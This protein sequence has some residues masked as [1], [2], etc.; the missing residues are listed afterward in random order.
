MD[1]T[2]FSTERLDDSIESPEPQHGLSQVDPHTIGRY[3]VIGRLGSGAFGQ[4]YLAH[5]DDLDRRVAIKVPR[6]GRR[7]QREGVQQYLAEARAVA[8]LDHANI[9]PVY[10][11]G[12]SED[13]GCYVVS[14]FVEG[15]DLAVRLSE[16][17]FSHTEAVELV[18]TV[19][20]SLHHAHSRGLVHRDIKPANILID[21]SGRPS[22]ADFGLAL[23]DEDF[24]TGEA[25]AGT[26]AYMSPEQA[27]GEGHRVDGRSDVF[28]LGIIFYELLAGRRPFR[29]SSATE[30]LYQIINVDARPPRQC[31][32]SIPKEL[33][34]ICLKALS[35]R[36][37]ERYNTAKD[38]AEDLRAFL[39]S[40]EALKTAVT[41]EV[42]PPESQG[43]S[44]AGTA[45]PPATGRSG[46]EV[47]NLR[48][49]PKGL[50]SFDAH[51]ADFFLELVPGAKDRNG[52]PE[53]LRFWKNRI[54]AYHNHETFKVGLIYG[55]SGCGKSSL[56]K[57][58]LLP[59]LA[60]N[61]HIVYAEA[62]P[63]ETEARL[64][65]GLRT[66]LAALP[67][68]L[69][70]VESLATI[71]RGLVLGSG[72]K[73]LLILDQFEQWLFANRDASGTELVAALR[74][75]DGE[76][77]QA[78]V[79]VRDDFWMAATR[80]MR[81]LE[82]RLVEGD[83]AA[84]VD[85][86]DP[87]HARNVLTAFG[88]A[89]GALPERSKDF[90]AD[91]RSFLERA[92]IDLVQD[93]KVISVRL[94]L[95]AQM[96]KAKPWTPA[97]L[98]A[99]GGTQ[100]VGVAFLDETFS[101]S[102]A[103]AEHRHHQR[104]AQ[105][106]LTALLPGSGT[107]IKGQMR[108]EAELRKAAGYESRP[109]DFDDLIRIL[110]DQLRLITP[111][112]PLDPAEEAQAITPDAGPYYQFTHDYLVPSLRE[113][114]TRRQR[115]TRQGRAQLILAERAGLWSAKPED[116]FL[117]S[118]VEWGS[119]RLL[120]TPKDW[121]APQRNM[122]RRAE[123][124]HGLR[125]L[126]LVAGLMLMVL[127]GL[128]LRG[129][130]VEAN[131]RTVSLGMVQQLVKAET[132]EV[133]G[134]IRAFPAHRR[135]IDP[136]LRRT[137]QDSRKES[138][139][140]LHA[141]LAL[142]PVDSA[143]ANY[144]TDRLLTASTVELPV[145]WGL[146]RKHSQGVDARLWQVVEDPRGDINK[147]FRA[148]CALASTDS[149]RTEHRWTALAPFVTERFLDMVRRNPAEYSTLINT[150]RPIRGYLLAPLQSIFRDGSRSASDLNFVTSILSDYA[151]DRPETLAELLTEA[152]APAFATLY[153]IAER[154]ASEVVPLL[155][156]QIEK[157]IVPNWR[158][159]PLSPAWAPPDP[160]LVSRIEE[161]Q[162]ML[163]ERFGFCQ[164]MRLN[165]FLRDAERL[166]ESG[167]RP[168]R[169][170]PYADGD[171]VRVA[172]IW[173]RDGARWVLVAGVPAEQLRREDQKHRAEKLLPLDVAGYRTTDLDG[174]P[175][176][177]YA[178]LWT[179]NDGRDADAR[180]YVG[181]TGDRHEHAIE[182]NKAGGF[183]PRTLHHF[184]GCDGQTRYSGIW[185]ESQSG[186]N[187]DWGRPEAAMRREL[188]AQSESRLLDLSLSD[189]EPS[190][191]SK[192]RSE[193]R[194]RLAD[195]ALRANPEDIEARFARALSCFGM[196]ESQNTL[197]D[198]NV[199]IKKNPKF[200][201]AYRC[202]AVVHARL[203][204]RD[205][206]LG[207]LA[208]FQEGDSPA[209]AK[210]SLA[211]VVAAE[212]GTGEDQSFGAL[213]DALKLAPS[214]PEMLYHACCALAQASQA[215]ATRDPSRS[216]SYARRAA[217]LLE[218]A[219]GNGYPDHGRLLEAIE[220]DPIRE[221]PQ[222]VDLIKKRNL[223]RLYAAVWSFE[224]GRDSVR[225][226]ALDPRA[227]LR[228]SRDLESQGYRPVSSS[229]ARTGSNGLLTTAMVWQR[230][231]VE[232]EAQDLQAER[233][234]RAAIALV[235]MGLASEV[236]PLLRHNAE[237]RLR[238]FIVNWLNPLGADFKAVAGGLEEFDSQVPPPQRRETRRTGAFLLDPTTSLRRA[239][240]L[241]LGTYGREG[242]PDDQRSR[243]TAKLLDVYRNDPDAGIHGAAEWTL[244]QWSGQERQR[245]GQSEL[246][247]IK[248]R[249]DRRWFVN[250]EG[251]TF[252]VIE[253]PVDFHMGSPANESGRDRNEHDHEVTIPRR[254][255]IATKEVTT[256]QYRR[257]L[258]DH[259]QLGL[260]PNYVKRYSPDPDGPI[261]AVSWYDA[262]SYCNWLS[263]KEGLPK[264]DWA[265]L[266]TENGLYDEGMTIPADSLQRR[267]YRLPT[268]AEWEYACRSGT[269]TSCFYGSSI[270]LRRNY[271]R[272][273]VNSGD[274]AWSCG[275]LLP[276]DL[277]LFDTLG[278]VFEWC[279]ER[280]REYHESSSGMDATGAL[281]VVSR[282]HPRI[283][284]GCSFND[285]ASDVRS[286]DRIWL[287]PLYRNSNLGFR[288]ARTCP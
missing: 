173:T 150:L 192:G 270:P 153:P 98:K 288:V 198:L 107:D 88:R 181:T 175:A 159:A 229:V 212:L 167:Y 210:V 233:Q 26:P 80:F 37:T 91:Q 126:G 71:R 54:E 280:T 206:A 55:P 254:F 214:D 285:L 79:M 265:Y 83:N 25:L 127:I 64:L 123:Q 65:R 12:R 256:E 114:L 59:R 241:A 276:N 141:S 152:A 205:E 273:Q 279:H 213:E 245:V 84:A 224:P 143:Q 156:N 77:V 19:A 32:D 52:L 267:G 208:R 90:T 22:V 66:A 67:P 244:R 51:D 7:F 182:G 3:R 133:P 113:W 118:L 286:A 124:V 215:Y 255:A 237:P 128:I 73:V 221:L 171:V 68:S 284:R 85:L 62:T 135:F 258:S 41:N 281:E 58:G 140:Y 74:H 163:S 40:A 197:D 252:A 47:P 188:I 99:V 194:R 138:K 117:P 28:S 146:L 238:S 103:S 115:E 108:S 97:T 36:A 105:A 180:I 57:A 1:E 231:V 11:V 268:E 236:W 43:S 33:E 253:G 78:I 176:D 72:Q 86:F 263:A 164:T 49:V 225:L 230:P 287:L 154:Q 249:D 149:G 134:I 38:M 209:G 195:D 30:M 95:F 259:P 2:R 119:I 274:H 23:V 132:S 129:R 178:A 271:A 87:V 39:S 275:G 272:F 251:H 122:I 125:A 29:G 8:K 189:F 234:A 9:V 35:K 240:I 217:S 196:G 174:N 111:T 131:E 179:A 148:A 106:I 6:S 166:R 177:R 4:V 18:A 137:T 96:V 50:R 161:G 5:D 147:R 243:L 282:G 165:D 219:V 151:S 220:L 239:L 92:V 228:K 120:T 48:V 158:D 203:N 104:A 246:S 207:D 94:A 16:S 227:Q 168:I 10:D 264:A 235:R 162:G 183:V 170:R 191:S 24:G 145:I 160:G 101:A 56:V 110:D 184:L 142:L 89:Y 257:F 211:C 190:R 60:R 144:L 13:G 130:V 15:C 100:G 44:L 63:E 201:N 204:H 247:T 216:Q 17:G 82:I 261:M 70:L 218:R 75:C 277:G 226:F 222:F 155:R 193:A 14:K 199:V 109:Q 34:R 112:D 157:K 102:T 202:R 169:F 121:T 172:A 223:D 27:R 116:R 266:P 21:T 262:V 136:V 187:L 269:S 242:S 20:E 31:L 139:A 185:V 81:E 250:G 248:V 283:L 42:A 278:N 53:G 61:I 93:G 200:M 46:S 45:L 232:E 69:G 260:D 186:W 76:H